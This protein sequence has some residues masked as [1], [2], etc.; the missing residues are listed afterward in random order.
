MWVYSQDIFRSHL[1][2]APGSLIVPLSY[3]YAICSPFL[4]SPIP[5]FST[6]TSSAVHRDPRFFCWQDNIQQPK[7]KYGIDFWGFIANLW[8]NDLIRNAVARSEHH[9]NW[10]LSWYALRMRPDILD[11]PVH[12]CATVG[13]EHGVML[14]DWPGYYPLPTLF[15]NYVKIFPICVKLFGNFIQLNYRDPV[16][17]GLKRDPSYMGTFVHA[18]FKV[19]YNVRADVLLMFFETKTFLPN[20]EYFWQFRNNAG[21]TTIA[22]R[23]QIG[24]FY[25]FFLLSLLSR[26]NCLVSR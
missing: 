24:G 5:P 3:F 25:A 6:S 7:P 10:F 2:C 14:L 4:Y 17:M 26:F 9:G 22:F 21:H 1:S 8:W 23:D 13:D 15:W 11:C 20:R 12:S 19:L 18:C 16:C